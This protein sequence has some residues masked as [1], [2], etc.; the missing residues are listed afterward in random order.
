MEQAR[1]EKTV[2]RTRVSF[3]SGVF[4]GCN[5]LHARVRVYAV[6]KTFFMQ[7]RQYHRGYP[8]LLHLVVAPPSTGY[9][10]TLL[11]GRQA[12]IWMYES[13]KSSVVKSI[14]G[15]WFLTAVSKKMEVDRCK[16]R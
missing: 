5:P 14:L 7:P 1:D 9:I 8:G 2:S 16:L 4:Y 12:A 6:A 13:L 3:C 15:S 11:A 10:A